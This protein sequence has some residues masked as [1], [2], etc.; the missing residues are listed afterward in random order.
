MDGRPQEVEKKKAI[1]ESKATVAIKTKPDA[2]TRI[3]IVN[4]RCSGWIALMSM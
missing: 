3:S 1:V 2:L 4:D